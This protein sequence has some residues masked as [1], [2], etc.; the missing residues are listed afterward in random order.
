[1]VKFPD[2]QAVGEAPAIN[3]GSVVQPSRGGQIIGA[4]VSRFGD[5]MVRVNDVILKQ[6]K[7][8]TDSLELAAANSDFT[9]RRLNEL[10]QYKLE[11]N[12]DMGK[13]DNQWADNIKKH[14]DAS[15]KLISNPMLRERFVATTQDDI[16]RGTL[17]VK[18]RREDFDMSVKKGKAMQGLENN[19]QLASRPGLPQAEVDKIFTQ[20]RSMIDNWVSTGVMSPEKAIEVRQAFVTKTSITRAQ[21][22]VRD[23]PEQAL[24][25]LNGGGKGPT[26][27]AA[28]FEGFKA[29]PYQDHGGKDGTTPAGLRIGYGS[30]TITLADGQVIPVKAGMTVTKV[31]AQRDLDRRMG[32]IQADIVKDIG[33]DAWEGLS[34]AAKAGVLSVSYNYTGMPD[35]IK[36]AVKSGDTKAI[37]EAVRSLSK[38]NGGINAS[39]RQKEA[40]IIEG[41]KGYDALDPPDY[42]QFVPPD[43]RLRLT[44]TAEAMTNQKNAEAERDTLIT[45]A[46]AGADHAMANP[47]RAKAYEIANK[48]ADP[49]TRQ[50]TLQIM[51]SQYNRVDENMKVQT[52]ESYRKAHSAVNEAIQKNDPVAAMK[53]IPADLPPEYQD[54][55]RIM[56]KEGRAK[57][58]D[59]ATEEMLTAKRMKDPEG[60]A[61]EDLTKYIGKLSIATIDKLAAEQQKMKDPQTS[62]DMNATVNASEDIVKANLRGIGIIETGADASESDI[63]YGLKIRKMVTLE[64]ERLTAKLGRTPLTSEMQTTIDQTFKSFTKP[65]RFWGTTEGNIKD[66]VDAYDEAG[67]DLNKATED[68]I[69]RGYPVTP[70]NLQKLMPYYQAEPK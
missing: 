68:L 49:K 57:T 62:K 39:R 9:A 4:A 19:L 61:K 64:M 56:I 44:T 18:G 43:D 51:D 70:E 66:I 52:L 28:N 8:Q 15:A 63:R 54:N 23:D 55:L 53:A 37:A 20:S 48:I 14:Q 10:D 34:P 26:A 36:N 58:D 41:G 60:F 32:V 46:Q 45:D 12:P 69:S 50:A 59:A 25:W 11:N 24:K 13:W 3:T 7:D 16:V 65:G 1:M 35:R 40:A 17:D 22:L 38:D 29:E 67:V 47:D 5:N 31:D 33:P 21:N 27:V 42:L 2:F 6:R 30:D